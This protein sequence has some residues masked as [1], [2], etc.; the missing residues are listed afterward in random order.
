M[1]C[2][3]ILSEQIP[4]SEILI[5]VTHRTV[6][7]CVGLTLYESAERQE[8]KGKR[9]RER[10]LGEERRLIHVHIQYRFPLAVSCLVLTS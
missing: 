1:E 8:R 5:L 3:V 10:V 7:C 4:G 2:R 6:L 9:G